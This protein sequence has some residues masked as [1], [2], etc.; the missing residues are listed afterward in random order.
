[1]AL[2]QRSHR[3]EAEDGPIDATGCIRPFYHKI[4][5]FIVLV[6]RGNLVFSL[7]LTHK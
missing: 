3:V 1:V 2:S 6:S 4:V 5:V 7:L